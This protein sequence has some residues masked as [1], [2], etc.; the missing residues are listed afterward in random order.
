MEHSTTISILNKSTIVKKC[1]WFRMIKMCCLHFSSFF[2]GWFQVK[3][4]PS[5]SLSQ[6]RKHCDEVS[7]QRVSRPLPTN[8][9]NL[10]KYAASRKHIPPPNTLLKIQKYIPSHV[11]LWH[12]WHSI[13]PLSF[14]NLCDIFLQRH[15]IHCHGAIFNNSPVWMFSVVM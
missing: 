14:E 10:W 12:F 11:F 4:F 2:Q 7:S 1:K 5:Y 15:I 3:W 6:A 8:S 13:L 9:L